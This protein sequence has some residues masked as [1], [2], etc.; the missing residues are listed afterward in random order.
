MLS[1]IGLP[2]II[3]GIMVVAL[4]AYV[5]M[6]GADFGGGVW[7]LLARG[8][9]RLRQRTLIA[10]SIAP[11][12]EANHV[13]LIVVVVML[14][15]AFPLAFNELG[16]VLHIPLTIMLIGIV[17][18]G[19]A[20]VF[21]SYGGEGPAR[22]RWGVT[23]AVASTITP[24]ILGMTI[25]ALASGAVGDASRA[26]SAGSFA[27]V[28]V[29]P[30]LGLFPIAI[31]LMA[32]SLF[33]FL[34]AVYLAHA[35]TDADLREDFRL[36]A[37]GAAVAVFAFAAIGLIVAMRS[38]PIMAG[39]LLAT[40]WALVLHV[41]IGASATTAIWALWTRRFGLARVAAAAQ[42]SLILWGWVFAQYPYILPTS[43]RIRD[44][45]APR[46]TLELLLGGLIAG[47]LILIPSLRYLLRTFAPAHPSSR[48]S[49]RNSKAP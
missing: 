19:T 4:N 25:G 5:L 28:Y 13:W 42:V 48:S 20:F 27:A 39:A 49:T 45:A 36:R 29:Q 17:L 40:G 43:M 37:L 22:A 7:D 30:W 31:G 1:Q 3:A 12:W 47:A 23:F 26:V 15:T 38:A 16:I 6:G 46:I 8:P 9:R 41:V 10:N 34:A 21:R 14:F 18:R 44:A 32:L 33:A 11:I 35:S 2:E 24:L